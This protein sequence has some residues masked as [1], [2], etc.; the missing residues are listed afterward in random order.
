MNPREFVSRAQLKLPVEQP[1]LLKD[2]SRW[3]Q[4]VASLYKW[5]RD[6]EDTFRAIS[7]KYQEGTW[8]PIDASGASLSFSSA[9][10]TWTKY[11]RL[12]TLSGSW[13]YPATG[14][15]ANAA[16]GGFPFAVN[17]TYTPI[18]PCVIT[19]TGG[20]TAVGGILGTTTG[21]LLLMAGAGART[22]A[23][24]SGD[25]VIFSLAYETD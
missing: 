4:F 18:G 1:E 6:L 25:T 11:G 14:S 3:K 15:G 19:D 23:Q 16:V 8:T 13:I 7:N 9:S 12:V 21:L 5:S 24:L 20:T 22:N 10:G 17:S 2:D